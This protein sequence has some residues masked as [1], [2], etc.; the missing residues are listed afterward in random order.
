[1][2]GRQLV[3]AGTI[4][5]Y[6][7]NPEFIRAMDGERESAAQSLSGFQIQRL[8]VGHVHRCQRLHRLQCL[9]GC[10]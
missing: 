7:K 4:S 1:M 10:L 5:E 9:R 3:R 8:C 6:R 2:E